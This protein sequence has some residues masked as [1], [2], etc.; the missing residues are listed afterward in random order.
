M[1]KYRNKITIIIVMLILLSLGTACSNQGE[2]SDLIDI[3]WQW[4][5]LVENEPASQSVVPNPENYTLTLNSDGTMN[6]QA[7]CNMVSGTYTL[8]GDSLALEFG[9]STMAFCGEESLDLLFAKEL[10][11]VES[12]V[13]DN[14]QLVLYLKN[15]VGTM[16]FN[17]Q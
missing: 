17:K 9:P 8:E 14:N 4:A 5:S 15:N 1:N 13:I 7:D 3:T 12:Y 2:G 10:N 16:S 11:V 6:I